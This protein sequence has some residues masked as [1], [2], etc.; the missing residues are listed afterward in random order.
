MIRELNCHYVSRF[1]TKPWQFGQA[2]LWYYDFD[3]KRIRKKSSQ[4]LFAEVSRNTPEME[5][6]LNKLIETPISNAIQTLVPSGDMKGI[7]IGEWG[8]FRALNLLLWLQW[9]RGSEDGLHRFSL[10]EVLSWDETT[11]DQFVMACQETHR[12][13][14]VRGD[15]RAPLCY[16]SD[17]LFAVPAR[18]QCGLYEGAYAIPLTEQYAVAMVPCDVDMAE[19]RA[20][21]QGGYL[22]MSSVGST[23]SRVVIHPS[24]IEACDAPTVARMIEDARKEVREGFSLRR[25]SNELV[26]EM[27]EMWCR[28]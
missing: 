16:P 7:E 3:S 19:F 10:E 21:Y 11:L 23:A 6:R 5:T 27:Y 25:K 18:K 14:G 26:R 20:T 24:V 13:V 17:G 4:S 1:L 28:A 15:P 2:M 8:L 22:A 12:I 9:S